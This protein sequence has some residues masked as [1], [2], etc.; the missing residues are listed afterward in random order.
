MK[1]NKKAALFF[2]NSFT[3]GGAERVCFDLI[4]H[5]ST[6]EEVKIVVLD[7]ENDY[8]EIPSSC[9]ILNLGIPRDWPFPKRLSKMMSHLSSVNSFIGDVEQ[10]DLI[11]AHLNASQIIAR[12]SS[13]REKTLYVMHGAQKAEKKKKLL[14]DLMIKFLFGNNHRI[15]C[16]S[17]GIKQE[18]AEEYSIDPRRCEVI[19]NP[20]DTEKIRQELIEDSSVDVEGP[21]VLAAGRLHEIKRFDRL[22]EIFS[23]M[24]LDDMKLVI[25]GEGRERTRLESIAK[26]LGIEK[27]VV[28]PG[29][30]KNPYAWMASS[31]LFFCCSDSEAFPVGLLEALYCGA[32]V[33]SADC[34]YGPREILTD[35]LSNF[36]VNPIDDVEQYVAKGYEAL[37]SYPAI[38]ATYFNRFSLE[39]VAKQYKEHWRKCFV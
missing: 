14:H 23:A 34:D 3:G 30:Q 38:S 29:F 1:A 22:L 27:K 25:I 10:Y 7:G 8:G 33:V 32:R 35:D 31:S 5:I 26:A 20:L 21:F 11:T 9:S 12:L 4:R 39:N 36:L 6:N 19:Y 28:F 24:K 2:V 13:V 17:D 16:V 37:R 18:L 15:I